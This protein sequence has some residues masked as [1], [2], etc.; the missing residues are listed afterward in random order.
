MGTSF[1]IIEH[2]Y[3]QTNVLMGFAHEAAKRSKPKETQVLDAAKEA[4]QLNKKPIKTDE[5]IL[6]GAVDATPG[7]DGSD[8][9]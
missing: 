2:H 4:S 5:I 9:D 8:E 3:G 1:A 6:A 7:D